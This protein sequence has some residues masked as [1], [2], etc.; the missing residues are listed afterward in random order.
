MA[1]GWLKSHPMHHRSENRWKVLPFMYQ[2]AVTGTN[3]PVE[4]MPWPYTLV[5]GHGEDKHDSAYTH[6]GVLHKRSYRPKAC[7]PCL[8]RSL[9]TG[10]FY[11]LNTVN[12]TSKPLKSSQSSPYLYKTLSHTKATI[13]QGFRKRE[14]RFSSWKRTK[15]EGFGKR[16]RGSVLCVW[17]FAVSC[18]P[19]YPLLFQLCVQFKHFP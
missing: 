19:G 18:T 3:T 5:R 8:C 13:L 15:N 12:F 9:S 11:T 1:V 16:E 2:R 14:L 4:R 10:S 17:R 6:G 7:S